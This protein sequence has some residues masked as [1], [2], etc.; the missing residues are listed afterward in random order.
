MIRRALIA[1]CALAVPLSL[2]ADQPPSVQ[3]Q[4]PALHGSRPLEPATEKAVLQDYLQS[5]QSLRSALN[6][7]QAELLDQDFVGTALTRLAQTVQ[8]QAAAGIHA[9]YQD[10]SHDL[11]IVFYS[12]NGLSIQ[13][14]DN[15]SYDEE[16]FGPNNAV[17]A[18]HRMHAR[19]LI[20]LTPAAARW[21]V[22]I[23]QAQPAEAQP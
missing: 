9:E 21:Q 7:N 16:V 12:P 15:V 4:P 8:E 22:R 18:T 3:V 17:L 20:V 1:A 11:Q 2:W 5:W 23:F 6:L 19:Y 14:V 13:M 10:L